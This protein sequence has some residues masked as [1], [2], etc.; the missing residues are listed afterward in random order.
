MDTSGLKNSPRLKP[1]P[2]SCWKNRLQMHGTKEAN[3]VEHGT[4]VTEQT[5]YHANEFV[6]HSPKSHKR[7]SKAVKDDRQARGSVHDH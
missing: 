6:T 4:G 7:F 3:V 2:P 5:F 1:R